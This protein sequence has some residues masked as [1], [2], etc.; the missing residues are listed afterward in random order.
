M[1]FGNNQAATFC[2]CDDKIAVN[3]FS[4]PRSASSNEMENF[5]FP[6]NC[7]QV[8]MRYEWVFKLTLRSFEKL[9]FFFF[10]PF[11]HR[12]SEVP[13]TFS[14]KSSST[15]FSFPLA[16]R[17]KCHDSIAS[18]GFLTNGRLPRL[19]CSNT[20]TSL[21]SWFRQH[22]QVG[23]MS[24]W[25]WRALRSLH[26]SSNVIEPDRGFSAA[27]SSQTAS[28]YPPS[29]IHPCFSGL[30]HAG[31]FNGGCQREKPLSFSR[32]K[33]LFSQSARRWTAVSFL[34]W[35]LSF[36]SQSNNSP[37]RPA[38]EAQKNC[39]ENG[40]EE[41]KVLP[42]SASFFLAAICKALRDS[43]NHG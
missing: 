23:Q 40:S 34:C 2:S 43:M 3:V 10:S 18:E 33:H 4:R 29:R 41:A 38:E 13:S 20:A 5:R 26:V 7:V 36:F 37:S 32:T 1:T 22:R 21:M 27:T 35:V 30:W 12:G 8:S 15:S 9:I 42:P 28:Q 24:D 17:A 14:S 19:R 25:S 6:S 11:R 31:G 39:S 16:P